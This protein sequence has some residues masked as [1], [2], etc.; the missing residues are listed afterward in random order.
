MMTTRAWLGSV[1]MRRRS[2]ADARRFRIVERAQR[3]PRRD[4]LAGYLDLVASFGHEALIDRATFVGD[5][6]EPDRFADGVA[7]HARADP[8]DEP[9][10]APDRL[11]VIEH[12]PLVLEG[13]GDESARDARLLLAQQRLVA[14]EGARR[15]PGHA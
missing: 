8:T 9:S 12:A 15:A 7:E 10:V 5:V 14:E 6:A 2:S 13:E 11:V 1:T 4:P 3:G